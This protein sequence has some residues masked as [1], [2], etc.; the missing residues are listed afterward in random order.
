ML[1]FNLTLSFHK[2]PIYVNWFISIGLS[3]KV[4]WTKL[5]EFISIVIVSVQTI[6]KLFSQVIQQCNWHPLCENTLLTAG[7][8]FTKCLHNFF[9][10][11]LTHGLASIFTPYKWIE[12]CRKNWVMKLIVT[13]I[14]PCTFCAEVG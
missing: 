12:H 7:F 1:V 4:Q 5:K 2:V 13:H 14:Y 9:H 11:L 3:I 8:S 6:V 10:F